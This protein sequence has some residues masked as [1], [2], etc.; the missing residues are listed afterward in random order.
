MIC[1]NRVV[2]PFLTHSAEHCFVVIDQLG[3]VCGYVVTAPNANTFC[4]NVADKWLPY[5][6]QKYPLPDTPTDQSAVMVLLLLLSQHS[7]LLAAYCLWNT[8]WMTWICKWRYFVGPCVRKRNWYKMIRTDRHR[9][10]VKTLLCSCTW[11]DIHICSN[12]GE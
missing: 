3:T 11:L 2:G 10:R 6:Q 7:V 8:M 1:D 5:L 4:D 9:H 12:L